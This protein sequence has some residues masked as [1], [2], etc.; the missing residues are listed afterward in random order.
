MHFGDI[1]ASSSIIPRPVT[2]ST[3]IT[4]G[5]KHAI[6]AHRQRAT[7]VV[8]DDLRPRFRSIYKIFPGVSMRCD[9]ARGTLYM[10]H[11]PR[12]AVHGG[13]AMTTAQHESARN[14]RVSPDLV[15]GLCSSDCWR[16]RA[17]TFE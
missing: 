12:S 6:H 15:A 2:K 9:R 1:S 17:V 7:V 11:G 8:V 10:A 16:G 3:E 4:C 14:Y 13:K 5:R